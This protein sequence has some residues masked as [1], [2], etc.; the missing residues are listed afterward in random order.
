[1]KTFLLK[2]K[3]NDTITLILISAI[4]LSFFLYIEKFLFGDKFS[5]FFFIDETYLNFVNELKNINL[6]NSYLYLLNSELNLKENI[7]ISC[8]ILI[9]YF[10]SLF[11]FHGIRKE[12]NKLKLK[13]KDCFFVFM[14]FLVV[15][16][17]VSFKN[18]MLLNTALLT[19]PIL[20][21]IP[22]LLAFSSMP[23]VINKNSYKDT[24]DN[25]KN[26]KWNL[27]FDILIVICGAVVL[28]P[29]SVL[30]FYIYIY[31]YLISKIYSI[32]C[33]K[34]Q[35][36]NVFKIIF[37]VIGISIFLELMA[38]IDVKNIIIYLYQYL[39]FKEYFLFYLS[40][41]AIIILFDYIVKKL[42]LFFG[43]F[44]FTGILSIMCIMYNSWLIIFLYPIVLK[45]LVISFIRYREEKKIGEEY[46]SLRYE[47]IT[48]YMLYFM[49]SFLN[50]N[51][52][53]IEKNVFTKELNMFS[54][55]LKKEKI[56]NNDIYSLYYDPNK[57]TEIIKKLDLIEKNRTEILNLYLFKNNIEKKECLKFLSIQKLNKN[58][59]FDNKENLYIIFSDEN[60]I[61]YTCIQNEK[62]NFDL[63]KGIL[64]KYGLSQFNSDIL[65]QLYK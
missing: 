10:F 38:K 22:I 29:I 17:T 37:I 2:I 18:I 27:K 43:N 15:V 64:T 33:K 61:F 54:I 55:N 51:I 9:I 65:L 31:I 60:N 6:K 30:L 3:K 57:K 8:N 23:I 46:I 56:I 19:Q 7:K 47:A 41:L 58:N 52:N 44:K 45:M 40:L 49:I 20:Y 4:L 53:S 48:V 5:K 11:I 13:L 50:N 34:S 36:N 16:T 14:L 21:I 39:L 12:I 26:Y 25:I 32:C 28:L 35:V 59:F 42:D 63:K 1:M 24:K 62:G